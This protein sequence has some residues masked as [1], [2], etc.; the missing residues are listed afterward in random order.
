MTT[1]YKALS[2]RL[3]CG[4]NV[5]KSHSTQCGQTMVEFAFILPAFLLLTIG[6]IFG[7]MMF[8]DGLTADRAAGDCATA[9]GLYGDQND[10]VNLNQMKQ[11]KFLIYTVNNEATTI[12]RTSESGNPPYTEVT[13]Q[14]VLDRKEVPSLVGFFIAE[15]LRREKSAPIINGSGS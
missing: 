13:A 6:M 8:M 14:I 15:E 11:T 3:Q 5:L 12:S 9:C 1:Q 10:T 4:W 7:G 2:D